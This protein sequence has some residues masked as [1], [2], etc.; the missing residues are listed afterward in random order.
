MAPGASSA[1]D[2]DEAMARC[3]PRAARR[4]CGARACG[5]GRRTPS[6]RSTPGRRSAAR[7]SSSLARASEVHEQPGRG[8]AGGRRSCASRRGSTTSSASSTA[9]ASS[10]TPSGSSPTARPATASTTSHG[11]CSSPTPWL[12]AAVACP[13]LGAMAERSLTF[14]EE[15]W[16]AGNAVPCATSGRSAGGGSTQPH[17]GDHVGRAVWALGEV[18]SGSSPLA[19]RSRS[20]LDAVVAAWPADAPP[21]AVAFAVLGLARS[22]PGPADAGGAPLARPGRRA[23][24]RHYRRHRRPEWAWFEDE[25]TYDN[26]RLPQALIAAAGPLHDAGLLADGLE[27]LDWYAQRCGLGSGVVVLVGNR[28]RRRSENPTGRRA[29]RARPRA[30]EG[31][32]QPLDAA[33]LVEAC[34]EAYRATGAPSW[35]RHALEAYGWFHGANRWRTARVR[36]PDRRLPR[37]GRAPAGSTS[38]RGPSPPSPTS[39]PGWP[40][41]T[42]ASPPA[43]TGGEGRAARA[44]RVADPARALRPLGTGHRRARRRPRAPRGRRHALRHRRLADRRHPR[45]G[46]P[47]RLCRGPADGRPGVGGP[48]R[49]PL[50]RP[51]LR[52]STS[53][54]ATSTG[55]RSASRSTSRR[56]S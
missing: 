45:V 12:L 2:D 33:A 25:L 17:H 39:R 5:R 46:Q 28:W 35:G 44:D 42:P 32:E 9:A 29:G 31:D 38:T 53:S 24:G 49:L 41:T 19:L 47:T 30:T 16:C 4:R 23:L 34:V 18:A 14:L 40:S 10:S 50:H 13:Q 22:S 6:A 11:C 7:C 26:A 27:A 3:A 48:A 43:P 52:S 51:V 21:R 15:A 55:S 54:T 20:L 8:H 56:R 37:R 1:F 36:R